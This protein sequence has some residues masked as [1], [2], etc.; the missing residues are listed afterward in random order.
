MLHE[1]TIILRAAGAWIGDGRVVAPAE[2]HVA[3]GCLRWIGHPGSGPPPEG[4]V[5][6][7]LGGQWLLP[8]LIDAHLH[9]WGLD[10]SDPAA[11]WNW[12]MAYRATRA[13]ADL[14]RMLRQGITAVRCLGG[15]LGPSLARAVREGLVEGPHVVAAGEFICA[16]AG[17]WDAVSFPQ[18]WVEGLGMF[19]DGA[20]ACRQRVRERIRQG[21]DFIKVGGSVGEHTDLLRP[22][23]DDPAHLRLAYSDG[24]MAV[25]VEEAHRNGLRVA[26]HAIGEAAVRQALDC[27]V[28]SIEHGHGIG[29]ET[30]RR[31]AGEGRML[32]PTLSLPVLRLAHPDPAV[33]AGWQRHREAQRRSLQ[34]ALRHGVRMAAGTDFVGPPGSPLGANA[35]E[36]EQLVDAGLTVE[37]ALLAGTATAAE[38]L[39]MQDRIGR[40]AVGLQADVVAVPG[41]P[42][43]DIGL[44]RRVGFVMK[45]GRV[46][47]G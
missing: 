4:A 20:D 32:V 3:G 42:R 9:L 6:R 24:E 19:A 22:W 37:Q 31:L 33:A 46:V 40:L 17:T 34:H 30:A 39:G 36:L 1:P 26:S 15:P 16:R 13:A 28:D 14:Q 8:G 25:L 38:A 43:A 21:A 29:D 10:L 11:L 2:L 35:M 12:P 5:V 27:G 45:G 47:L 18:S 41:D 23:G 44:V 7:E